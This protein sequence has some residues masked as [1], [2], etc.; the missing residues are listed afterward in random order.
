MAK[1]PTTKASKPEADRSRLGRCDSC[2]Q[3]PPNYAPR[4][5][6]CPECARRC[7][8]NCRAG[9][10]QMCLDCENAETDDE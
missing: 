5:Y 10:N 8:V 2:G 1:R 4:L 3:L 9:M 6:E 7:C